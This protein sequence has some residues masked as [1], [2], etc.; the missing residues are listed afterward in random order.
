MNRERSRGNA[1]LLCGVNESA[2]LRHIYARSTAQPANLAGGW[3]T[4]VGPGDDAAVLRGPDGSLIVQTVDQVIAGVH[5]V[6]ETALNQI[7]RKAVA[8]SVSDLAAMGATPSWGTATGVLPAG[9]G[10]GKELI[11]ALQGWG[12]H[13]GCPLV[14][15]DLAFHAHAEHPLTL[16]VTLCGV[17]ET[18]H[19]PVLRSGARPGD[20]VFV[21]GPIGDSFE[22]GWHLSFEPRVQLGQLAGRAHSGVRSMIDVSDGLG[23]DAARI[24]VA[25][26]VRL[27]IEATRVPLRNEARGWER[28]LADGEDYELLL[29]GDLDNSTT[30]PNLGAIE[31]GRVRALDDG[32]TPGVTIIDPQGKQHDA[33]EA[34]WDHA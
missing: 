11:D 20:R 32:E 26:G 34:G 5:F 16:T 2:L 22:T 30:I 24:G 29:T 28:A 33:A 8:R 19:A 21:T 18:G 7:A 13:W 3:Q 10:R 23:R 27:E 25:S 31:I 14:G 9:F 6:H 12:D 15:G 4:V 1:P 17:F